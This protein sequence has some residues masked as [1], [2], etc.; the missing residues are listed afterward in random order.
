MGLKE[1][2]IFTRIITHNRSTNQRLDLKLLLFRHK[3]KHKT[4]LDVKVY[5]Q[6]T[7]INLLTFSNLFKVT[8]QLILV[9]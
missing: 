4:I 9:N 8:T 3:L 6:L 7:L 2:N 1:S 5:N